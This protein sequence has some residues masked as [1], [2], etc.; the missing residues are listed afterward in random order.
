MKVYRYDDEIVIFIYSPKY[1][2]P[3]LSSS[4]CMDRTVFFDPKS[5]HLGKIYQLEAYVASSQHRI[6]DSLEQFSKDSVLDTILHCE[7]LAI[8]DTH[9]IESNED[10]D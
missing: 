2:L 3:I 8:Y 1:L 4:D 5:P 9:F 10:G 6:K 7:D